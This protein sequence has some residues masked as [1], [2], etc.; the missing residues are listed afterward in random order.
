MAFNKINYGT[1]LEVRLFRLTDVSGTKPI[2]ISM[3]NCWSVTIYITH[4]D[5]LIYVYMVALEGHS[6]IRI[7][8]KCILRTSEVLDR[9]L[10]E[11]SFNKTPWS[12]QTQLYFIFQVIQLHVLIPIRII[13][14]LVY[15][16]RIRKVKCAYYNIHLITKSQNL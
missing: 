10:H 12:V 5:S 2:E 6:A 14:R 7:S 3:R 11:I 4:C 13:I 9:H 8:H 16:N 15:K 1:K